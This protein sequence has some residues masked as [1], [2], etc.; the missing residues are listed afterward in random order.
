MFTHPNH[1]ARWLAIAVATG[2]LYVSQAPAGK[3]VKPPPDQPPYMLVDLLGFPD[4]GYQSSA[5]FITDRDDDGNVL[6]GG[7]S[8]LFLDPDGPADFHPA[9]GTSTCWGA[10]LPPSQWI[11]ACPPLRGAWP[12]EA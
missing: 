4:N 8:R 10:F 9:L 11:W 12:P 2:L 3:P 6:I 5:M 7:N 1:L